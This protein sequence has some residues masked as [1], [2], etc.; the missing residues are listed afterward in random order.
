LREA[1]P[2]AAR[3]AVQEPDAGRWSSLLT[4]AKLGC[5]A[6]LGNGM[7]RAARAAGPGEARW[8]P[9]RETA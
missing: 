1:R 3:Q 8:A 6:G 9:G 7:R 5:R 4:R 2:R